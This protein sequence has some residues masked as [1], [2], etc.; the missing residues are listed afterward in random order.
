[1]NTNDSRVAFAG[2][3]KREQP[4]LYNA[5]K[6][7][8]EAGRR[9]E[10]ARQGNPAS[11]SGLGQTETGTVAPQSFWQKFMSGLST[12]ATGALAYSAQK[13]ILDTNIQRA[14]QGL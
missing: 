11:I 1:M 9:R 14:E 10:A 7:K 3:L 4:D 2:W 8:A 6:K 12:L 5:A 13:R